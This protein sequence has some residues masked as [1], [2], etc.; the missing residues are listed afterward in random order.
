MITHWT[1]LEANGTIAAY[2][3]SI[4][5]PATGTEG[6]EDAKITLGLEAIQGNAKVY[7]TEVS[8][9]EELLTALNSGK[10]H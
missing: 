8:T 3:V 10:K 1:V 4:E 2:E 5:V 7:D 6:V 9:K